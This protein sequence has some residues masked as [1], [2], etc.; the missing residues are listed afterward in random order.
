MTKSPMRLLFVGTTREP[1]G[2][3]SHFI[4]LTTAMAA[5][6]HEVAA[7]ASP[8]SGIWRALESDGRV[9]L[10]AG[11]F[12]QKLDRSGMSA[13]RKASGKLRPDWIIGAFEHDYWGT[14][15]V[16]AA[17]RT[18]LA[19]FLHHAHLKRSSKRVLPWLVRRFLLP[20]EYLRTWVVDRG[21]S[22]SRSKVLFNPIDT[23]HFHPCE[24]KRAV[25][26]EALG[27]PAED[28]LVGFVGRIEAHKGVLMYAEALTRAMERVPTLRALW[29]GFGQLEADVDN[30]I[31]RSN[32]SSRHVRMPWTD[33]VAP[34][35]AAM[36]A[37]AMPSTGPEA[38]GRV[39]VE[40]QACGVPVLASAIGG[41]GETIQ[42]GTTGTLVIPSDVDA[43][44][45]ALCELATDKA[46][47]LAMGAAGPGFVRRAFDSEHIADACERV[48]KSAHSR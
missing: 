19:L 38:F 41:I 20:S 4:S 30:I 6:G 29:V 23:R 8:D 5:A 26:R 34:H 39:S 40:A 10:Y 15:L 48:L 21:L 16:A 28:V 24:K 7:V 12:N 33:D 45:T 36:D 46:R 47:R 11:E 18:P 27:I 2:A 43:W 42:A 37:L 1:G 14:A 22:D 9:A 13:V 44:T 3:A 25:Q 32:F 17:R 31:K 35:Y